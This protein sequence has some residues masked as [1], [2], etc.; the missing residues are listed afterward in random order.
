MSARIGRHNWVCIKGN[1]LDG[2][3]QRWSGY[4]NLNNLTGNNKK[5]YLIVDDLG[6]D[7]IID[8][9]KYSILEIFDTKTKLEA[10]IERENYWK[11]VLD[12]KKQGMNHN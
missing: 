5:F 3:W 9:F 2:I 11:N 4:A 1:G 10:V 8:N 7:H 6:K 12:S